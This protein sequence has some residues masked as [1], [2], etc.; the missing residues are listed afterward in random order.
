VS[1]PFVTKALRRSLAQIRHVTP[2]RPGRAADQLVGRVYR[3]V[4]RDFGMLAPPIALHSPAPE[5]LAASWLMLR[6][7][8]VAAGQADRAVK[9]VVASAVSVANACPYCVAVH[10]ATLHG[11]LRGGPATAALAGGELDRIPD[12]VLRAVAEWAGNS[13][14]QASAAPLPEA[15][16]RGQA[17]ELIGVAVAFQYLNRMVSVFLDE[18]PLPPTVPGWM[19][20]RMLRVLGGFMRTA[21]GRAVAPGES[22]TLLPAAELP[23]DMSWA[24]GT[25][26]VAGAFARACTVV[27]AAGER[28]VPPAVRQLVSAELAGWHGESRGISRGWVNDA[29]AGLAAADRAAGT[30]ALLTAFAAY[31]V[32]EAVVDE[33]RRTADDA[34]VVALTSWASL[35][36][37]R[38]VGGWLG[39]RS[40]LS[41][42]APG[43]P[44]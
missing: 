38:R 9:E 28:A 40:V 31:Q 44:L 18:S 39:P 1:Q 17:P 22:L 21:A 14:R 13:G 11:L 30:L 7:T 26:A 3:Q 19:R 33:F 43:T 2:V 42:G 41:G 23:G 27:E 16:P 36:A 24:T 32:D 25:P 29:V 6:E 4:E 35:A 5:L 37:A 10:G 20:G 12:P 34:A 15:V 8:L